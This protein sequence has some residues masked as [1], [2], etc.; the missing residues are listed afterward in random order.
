MKRYEVH[1]DIEYQIWFILDTFKNR[2]VTS[3]DHHTMKRVCDEMN[4]KEG[5]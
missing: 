1:Y 2:R 4:W 5:L 3:G